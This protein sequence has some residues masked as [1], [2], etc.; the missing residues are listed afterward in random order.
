MRQTPLPPLQ[1]GQ[2]D[3]IKLSPVP[4]TA[5]PPEVRAAHEAAVR[6]EARDEARILST[7]IELG[8][9]I[10][11]EKGPPVRVVPVVHRRAPRATRSALTSDEAA[12]VGGCLCTHRGKPRG[13]GPGR[14]I[15]AEGFRRGS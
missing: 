15:W 4:T 5:I 12:R 10:G 7:G 3:E 13:W 1:K 9:P 6:E 11:A 8:P 2:S 14:G